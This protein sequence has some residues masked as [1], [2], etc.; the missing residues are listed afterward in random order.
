MRKY[1]RERE[2]EKKYINWVHNHVEHGV[3]KVKCTGGTVCRDGDVRTCMRIRNMV[4]DW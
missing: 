2:K 3:S 4:H 1:E